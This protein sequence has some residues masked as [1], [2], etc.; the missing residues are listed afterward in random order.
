MIKFYKIKDK[1]RGANM[2]VFC[3]IIEGK[4]PSSKIYEDDDVLAILD[5][6]QATKGHTLVMPKKHYENILQ[7]PEDDYIKVMSKVKKIAQVILKAFDAKG[8]NILNNCNEV[9]GQTVMHFHVHI[10]PRYN[11]DDIQIKFTDHS[12]QYNLEDI[13]NQILKQM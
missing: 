3:N 5:I 6:S 1:K 11:T 12:S 9:S 4:I 10:I 8:L 2:C 7:I 13:K